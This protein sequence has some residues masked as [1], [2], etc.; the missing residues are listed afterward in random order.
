[1]REI[2]TTKPGLSCGFGC[3]TKTEKL[4]CGL[5]ILGFLF[6]LLLLFLFTMGLILGFSYAIN[7]KIYNMSTGYLLADLNDTLL[8]ERLT[9]YG[10]GDIAALLGWSITLLAIETVSFFILF[11]LYRFIVQHYDSVNRKYILIDELPNVPHTEFDSDT[12]SL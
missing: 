5:R 12:G 8:A 1:M 3:R 7:S 4:A 2:N 6:S 9:F 10:H 11:T